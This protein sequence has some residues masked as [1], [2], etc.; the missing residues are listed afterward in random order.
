MHKTMKKRI[1]AMLLLVAMLVSTMAAC[2]GTTGNGGQTQAIPGYKVP[3]GGYDGSEVT[4][5]FAHTMGQNLRDVLDEYI[6]EF[7]KICQNIS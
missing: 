2:G 7:N 3:A 1:I 4:I 5:K 6:L